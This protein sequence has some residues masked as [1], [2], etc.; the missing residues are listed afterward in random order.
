LG[1]LAQ[2][3]DYGTTQKKDIQT[4]KTLSQIAPRHR[5]AKSRPLQKLRLLLHAA[6]GLRN[7]RMVQELGG[8]SA[9]TGPHSGLI[10]RVVD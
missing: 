10:M 1:S 6:Q 4:E 3:E 5:K 9:Q 7:L 8:R 2:E